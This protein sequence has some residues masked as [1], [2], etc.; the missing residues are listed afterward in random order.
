MNKN[1]QPKTN[2]TPLPPCFPGALPQMTYLLLPIHI[3]IPG[4]NQRKE[5]YTQNPNGPIPISLPKR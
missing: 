2:S 1:Y 5:R 4:P 3:Q